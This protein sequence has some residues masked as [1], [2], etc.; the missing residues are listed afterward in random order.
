MS[1]LGAILLLF[2]LS[3]IN[4][5]CEYTNCKNYNYVP[6]HDRSLAIFKDKNEFN[7]DEPWLPDF[8]DLNFMQA[9]FEKMIKDAGFM[10]AGDG[11]QF[12][13]YRPA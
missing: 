10:N 5:F 7:E 13:F 8:D 4:C 1:P 12:F 9:E 2:F 11:E 6:R 3:N